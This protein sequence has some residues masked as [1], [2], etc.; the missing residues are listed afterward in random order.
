[1][2]QNNI[3]FFLLFCFILLTSSFLFFGNHVLFIVQGESMK[4]TF[5]DCMILSVNN[6]IQPENIVV[7]NIVVI[8]ILDENKEFSKITHRVVSNNLTEKLISTRGDNNLFY[9]FSSSVD[10]FF[11]YNKFL[12]KVEYY[13]S[14]PEQ[15][16]L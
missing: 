13:F 10:G 11:G 2:K 4:P 5:S 6:L 14:L 16:C 15:F 7:G 8:D 9:D 12:G 3:I 1:M